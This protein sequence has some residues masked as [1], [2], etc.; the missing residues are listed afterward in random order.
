MDNV[1]RRDPNK[2]NNRYTLAQLK[3]MVPNFDWDAYLGAVG[4][5]A[6]PLY[7]VTAPEYFKALNGMLASEANE[8]LEAVSALA[9]CAL[10]RAGAGKQVAGRGL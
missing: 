9:A 1:T 4:A 3:Q 2:T 6:V 5:P 8:Q 10:G 7:E